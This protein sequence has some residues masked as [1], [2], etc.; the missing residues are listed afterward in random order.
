MHPL[1]EAIRLEKLDDIRY[2]IEEKKTDVNAKISM[3]RSFLFFAVWYAKLDIIQYLIEKKAD[4][5]AKD[6]FGS[7]ALHQAVFYQKLDVTQHLLEKKADTNA[8]GDDGKTPLHHAID[9]VN[10]ALIETL[11]RHGA[12]PFAIDA[13][14]P[15]K[16][17]SMAYHM[18]EE[19]KNL[20]RYS[21]QRLLQNKRSEIIKLRLLIPA[22]VPSLPTENPT[23]FLS[24]AHKFFNELKP[25][26]SEIRKTENKNSSRKRSPESLCSIPKRNK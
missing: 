2:L 4:V 25:D 10:I 6:K 20:I 3:E 16:I 15:L 8:K 7:T 13:D 24:R 1:L 9:C 21:I 12:N 14:Y 18:P 26:V 22:T 5:N 23:V 11:L 19:S 17:L